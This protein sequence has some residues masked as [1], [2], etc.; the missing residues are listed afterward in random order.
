MYLLNRPAEAAHGGP[1]VP[2]GGRFLHL[3]SL[4][5]VFL[6]R[7]QK[8]ADRTRTGRLVGACV[9]VCVCVLWV[10][11]PFFAEGGTDF[12]GAPNGNHPF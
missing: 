5:Q 7:E 6:G 12:E 11:Y 3:P 2:P 1:V 8:P 9:C 4:R 10:V